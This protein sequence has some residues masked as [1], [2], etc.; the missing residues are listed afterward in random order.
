MYKTPFQPFID[1]CITVWGYAADKYLNK[2]PRIMSRASR[3]ITEH[4]EYDI[5]G[6]ELLR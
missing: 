2:V 6:V 1:Y 4:F 3:I 5:R